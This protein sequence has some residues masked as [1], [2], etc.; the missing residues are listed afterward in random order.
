MTTP[1]RPLPTPAELAAAYRDIAR[2]HAEHLAQ[3]GVKLPAENSY[4]RA[5]QRKIWEM[6]RQ[7]FGAS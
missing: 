5:V 1:P 6:L 4:Q 3:H 7:R 2:I